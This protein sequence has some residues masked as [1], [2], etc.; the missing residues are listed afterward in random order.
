MRT[1]PPPC[2]AGK[3]V[4]EAGSHFPKFHMPRSAIIV[5]A[6]LGGSL[7]AHYLGQRGWDVTVYERRGDPRAKGHVGGRSINLA[8]SARGLK[9]LQRAGLDAAIHEHGIRMPG[10][11]LH[12]PAGATAF[13]PYS[14]DPTRAIMS[15]S[16][17]ALN[18][19]LLRAAAAH[20]TVRMQFDHRCTG[21][22]EAAGTIS[23]E[24]PDGTTATVTAD[25][26]VG[27]DGAFS[28]VR[29]HM[30]RRER[31]DYSQDY[32]G[33][34]YKELSI[35]PVASGPHAPF[36]MEPH[37]LHIWPRGGSMM[38]ALPNP[39]GSFTCT[40]FWPHDAP[41]GAGQA[42][43]AT[44]RTGADALAHFRAHYPD[45]VP[46]MPELAAEFDRNP[47]GSMVTIR[48][49]PWSTGGRFAL[50]GDAAHAIVPFYGQGAN[51]SFEDC[52][53]LVDA[54]DRHPGSVAAA[55]DD[56]QRERKPNADAIADMAQANFIEMRDLT[57]R[58]SF[59]WRKKRDHFL[60][61]L[62]PAVYVPLYDL[63]SFSTVPYA[64]ARARA[65]R[66]E[67]TVR[68]ATAMVAIVAV[69]VMA[70]AAR[71]A[72]TWLSAPVPPST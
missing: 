72:W 40:L 35:P 5:G 24:R 36:A 1:P 25:L 30:S 50:L 27:A 2:S 53:A 69:V 41:A 59:K 62:L 15:F 4:I 46:L 65:A 23:F 12:S 21:F 45:A 28:A 32:L 55:I 61:R 64:A 70:V 16:R 63:V 47:V 67:R 20:P 3:S 18:M 51:A 11:M 49:W 19:M 57:A 37:A 44:V 66:Q 39:D 17:S 43:F 13:V 68:A 7:L 56:Y 38:I 34:G 54:L 52:E 6:G 8:I 10:R 9:A 29:G 33:H 22:D 14:A 26:V 71:A 58:S 42:S 31:F 60:N 48:C